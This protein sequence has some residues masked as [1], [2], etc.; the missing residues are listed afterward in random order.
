MHWHLGPRALEDTMRACEVAGLV[1]LA[2]IPEP[3]DSASVRRALEAG[4]GGV[5]T[6]QC[7]PTTLSKTTRSMPIAAP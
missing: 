1:A 6:A 3:T 2:R 4:A 7:G 5:V